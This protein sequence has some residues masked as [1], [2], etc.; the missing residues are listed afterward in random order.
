MGAISHS[1]V[2]MRQLVLL[3]ISA[4]LCLSSAQ[5]CLDEMEVAAA[6]VAQTNLS[7]RLMSAMAQCEGGYGGYG[8]RKIE[9]KEVGEDWHSVLGRRALEREDHCYSAEEITEYF[10][11]YKS[12]DLC[13]WE[14]I[15]WY[16]FDFG[17]ITF[18]DL[19]LYD[20]DIGSLAPSV[21]SELSWSGRM[22]QCWGNSTIDLNNYF[23]GRNYT[24]DDWNTIFNI[25]NLWAEMTCFYD[26]FKESCTS[27]LREEIYNYS[28]G[29][30]GYGSG[31]YGSSGY[32]SY[33]GSSGY[34]SYYGS[35]GYGSGYYGSS[36]YG[37]YYGSSGYGSYYGSSGYGSYPDYYHSS[38]YGSSSYYG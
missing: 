30:S 2:R 35:S 27:F 1:S 23:V 5:L 16:N 13:I 29:S 31:Y 33:Y 19:S 11:Q 26:I 9:R 7:T 20:Q 15:G 37:S 3:S 18:F 36:G 8:G 14:S 10:H 17:D 32:G 22:G 28:Y 25:V 24:S 6:C 34:G 12:Y 21:S 38:G 4:L